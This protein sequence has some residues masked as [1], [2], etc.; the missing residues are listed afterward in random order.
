MDWVEYWRYSTACFLHQTQSAAQQDQ[1]GR[2]PLSSGHETKGRYDAIRRGLHQ[3]YEKLCKSVQT[4]AHMP[5][6]TCGL[7]SPWLTIQQRLPG[8]DVL[9]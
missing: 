1:T 6:L 7:E 2:Q 3:I 8:T 4:S 5:W 9:N